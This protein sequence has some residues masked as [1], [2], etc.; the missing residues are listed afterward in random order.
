MLQ[1]VHHPNAFLVDFR[2]IKPGLRA[3]TEILN[4][5]ENRSLDAKTIAKKTGV[6]YRSVLHHLRLIEN[7]GIVKRVGNRP[8]IWM[9]TGLG[10]KRLINLD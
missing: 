4:I 3:R 9:I 5:L 8:Y 7:A 10:Q 2:N 1:G 6:S